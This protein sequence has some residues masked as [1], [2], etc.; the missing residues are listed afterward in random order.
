MRRYVDVVAP[1]YNLPPDLVDAIVQVESAGDRFAIR[2]EPAYPWLWDVREN[3]PFRAHGIA[4]GRL[5]PSDFRAPSGSTAL[6]EWIGQQTSWGLMQ[7]MGAVARELGFHGHFAGLCDPLEGLHY[8]CRL[9]ARLRDRHLATTGWAGV[10]D[11]YNDGSVRIERPFDY[12]HKVAAVSPA[13]QAL[14]KL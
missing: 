1:K 7:V 12:P 13:A 14:L 2:H 11:A 10:V 3:R 4:G 5:P 9:L 6:T 8:G